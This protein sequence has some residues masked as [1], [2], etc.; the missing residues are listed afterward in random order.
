MPPEPLCFFLPWPFLCFLPPQGV[1]MDTSITAAERPQRLSERG[2]GGRDNRIPCATEWE[3]TAGPGSLTTVRVAYWTEPTHP[4][5]RAT[6][7]Q[8]QQSSLGVECVVVNGTVIVQN[9]NPVSGSS[10][11]LCG[12]YLRHSSTI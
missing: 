11:P 9:T 1:W 12:K 8:P 5:D 7:D 3:I 4:V 2:R 10:P 6:Y